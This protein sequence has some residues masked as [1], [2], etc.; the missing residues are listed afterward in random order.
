MSMC[1]MPTP[2]LW[3]EG[4][5]EATTL[6]TTSRFMNTLPSRSRHCGRK[7]IFFGCPHRERSLHALPA[8]SDNTCRASR[9]P[10]GASCVHRHRSVAGCPITR[11][12]RRRTS[13]LLRFRLLLRKK[14]R[15]PNSSFRQWIA[16]SLRQVRYVPPPA[17]YRVV[18]LHHYCRGRGRPLAG[19]RDP[20]RRR[21]RIFS[22][23]RC[24][25]RRGPPGI[26]TLRRRPRMRSCALRPRHESSRTRG[27][28]SGDDR[29]TNDASTGGFR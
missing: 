15:S 21:H 3:R 25:T 28:S 11:C 17:L 8:S 6:A 18:A 20:S 29:T 10:A 7:S 23:S 2:T 16:P 13:A 26:R 1:V 14:G 12:A 5:P 22:P 9:T 4:P 27:T 24:R 19:P